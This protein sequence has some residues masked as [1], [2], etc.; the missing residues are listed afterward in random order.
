[1]TRPRVLGYRLCS[2][3]LERDSKNEYRFR[4]PEPQPEGMNAAERIVAIRNMSKTQGCVA[5][6]DI[7]REDKKI[8]RLKLC[9]D[10][11]FNPV[12]FLATSSGIETKSLPSRNSHGKRVADEVKHTP[13]EPNGSLSLDERTASDELGWSSIA[14]VSN[15]HVA[16]PSAS[17]SGL[18]A[19]KGDRVDGLDVYLQLENE[20]KM[21]TRVKLEKVR[22]DYG[23]IWDLQIN[24]VPDGFMRE[25]GW[26]DGAAE[27]DGKGQSARTQV[28]P[29]LRS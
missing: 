17:R 8:H 6:V 9:F 5:T 22:T 2:T 10:F 7:A 25:V 28:A 20:W 18:W 3:L 1:M 24:N 11:Y 27:S 12:L 15:A 4:I 29:K 21:G 23:M 14:W 16:L 26:K 19:L 13:E